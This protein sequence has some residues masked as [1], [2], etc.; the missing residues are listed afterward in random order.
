MILIPSISAAKNK[1]NLG[2]PKQLIDR[3]I[4]LSFNHFHLDLTD[5][6]ITSENDLSLINLDYEAKDITFDYHIM[7]SNPSVI[8]EQIK[9]R[10]NTYVHVHYKYLNDIQKYIDL[11]SYKDLYVGITFELDD[12]F[13]KIANHIDQID[14]INFMSVSELGKTNLVF[15]ERVFE[16]IKDFKKYYPTYSGKL[17]VDGSVRKIHLRKLNELIDFCVVGSIVLQN[18]DFKNNLENLRKEF[19]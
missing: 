7:S 6:T 2:Y 10:K 17:M 16:K 8:I 19:N 5:S 1:T 13:S 14:L 3:L 9:K 4:L 11:L 15:D 18:D 12:D